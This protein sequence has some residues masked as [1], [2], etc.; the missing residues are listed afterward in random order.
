MLSVSLEWQFLFTKVDLEEK[1]M[2]V[3]IDV[4]IDGF[5]T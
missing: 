5:N 1:P 4:I 3:V 2:G